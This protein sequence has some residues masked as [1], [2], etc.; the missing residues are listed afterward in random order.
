MSHC[1]NNVFS[2]LSKSSEPL[3]ELCL[4][5]VPRAVERLEPERSEDVE[6]IEE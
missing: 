3:L 6:E 5:W 1:V 2:R 4:E